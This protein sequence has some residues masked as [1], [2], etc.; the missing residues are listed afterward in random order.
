MQTLPAPDFPTGGIICGYRGIK[1]AYYTGRG[2]LTLRAV[3][4]QESEERERIIIDEL[5]YN[6]NKALLISRIAELVNNKV[7]TGISDIRDESDK[8][9]LRILIELKRGEIPD[10]TINQLYK[11]TDL[12]MTFGCNMLALDNGLP[13]LMNIKQMLAAWIKHRIEVVRRRT[14]YELKKAQARAHLLEG[15]LIALENLD[16]IVKMIKSSNDRTE[17]K[18]QL[19]SV[20]K[21]SDKQADAVLE[22][23]LYQLTSLE[24]EK[25][26]NEYN[27]LQK[28]IKWL[29]GILADELLVRGIMKEELDSLEKMNKTPRKTQIIAAE[30]D[31]QIEDLIPKESVLITLSNDDYI[32]RMP[33]N[34]FR[35]QRRGGSGVIGF[36]LKKE[37]DSLKDLYVANTHDYLMV[38]TNFGRCYWVKVWEITEG[39]RR[40]KGKPVINLLEGIQKG[41]QIATI[42]SVPDLNKENTFILFATKC[43]I[44]KK[45]ALTNFSSPRRKG[46]Y[47][48]N[49]DDGDEVITVRLVNLEEQIMLFS[50]MGMAVRFD[51]ALVR[52]IGRTGRGV[53]GISLQLNDHVISCEVVRPEDHCFTCF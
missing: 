4:H 23:R 14:R 47:A 1:D 3:I 6:V 35:E 30:G 27:E 43:G 2:K 26:Q 44:I 32:K 33:I 40:S 12:Q 24:I 36:D 9:G 45:T 34:T 25:V 51:E 29:Q 50:H 15:Y 17:A 10:V 16:E 41:E 31:F 53:R 11:Y 20:Y 48:I 21:L 37:T 52:S 49:I 18:K 8:E 28:R 13:K 7:L 39:T 22:L 46:V 42:L 5:P 19:V 38:F